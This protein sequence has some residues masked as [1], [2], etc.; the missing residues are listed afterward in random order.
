MHTHQ[1]FAAL[2]CRHAQASNVHMPVALQVVQARMHSVAHSA[3]SFKASATMM[4]KSP[5]M[6]QWQHMQL[7]FAC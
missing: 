3:E 7:R 1:S 2:C 4:A 6:T 5:I